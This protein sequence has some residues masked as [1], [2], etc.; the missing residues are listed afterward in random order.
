[1]N[2]VLW[3]RRPAPSWIE[4]MPLGNGTLGAMVFG[5]V[6]N[7]RI[8]LNHE[9]LWRS[10]WRYRGAEER[11][12]R[13]DAVRERFFS[14]GDMAEAGEFAKAALLGSEDA[15]R[16]VDPYQPVGD[17]EIKL[18]KSRSSDYRRELDLRAALA[19]V[20]FRVGGVTH[21]RQTFAHSDM[22]VLVSRLAVSEPK[23]LTCR[24]SLTR[25][26]DP[27]C[28][29]D[30]WTEEGLLG[31][32]GE[33]VE[34]SR[35]ACM[36][37]VFASGGE[38]QYV[39][40]FPLANLKDC[41]DALLLASVAV[42]HDGADP[43]ETCLRQLD[44]EPDWDSLLASHRQA[45]GNL[46]MRVDLDL[47]GEDH[48]GLSTDER[49]AAVRDGAEDRGLLELYFNLGRYLLISSSR[50]GGL[51]TNLQGVWNDK[52][53]PP[54][55]CDFH[56]D[57]NIQMNYWPAEPCNLPECIAPFFDY[58]EGMVPFAREM[59]KTLFNCRGVHMAIQG[60]P[61]GRPTLE[62]YGWALWSGAAPWLA[63]HFWWRDEYSL[64]RNF[65]RER[66]YPLI[67]DVALFYED[68]LVRDPDGRLV[69]VPSQSPENR[70]VGGCS[71]VSLC[72]GATM[73]LELI[74]DVL[75]HAV[76]AAG[77]LG[78]DEEKQEMWRTI[79]ADLPP[80]RIGRHG[81][82]Q[83]WLEDYEE[84]EPGHRHMSHL[85]GLHPGDQITIDKTPE[86]AQAARVSL[87]R[88][89]AAGGGQ[90]GWSRAWVVSF[91]ARLR[92]G[93]KALEHLK[94]LPVMSEY[95]TD[96]LLDLH[97]P[98]IFQID[99]NLGGAAGIAEM[100]LQSH[101][102]LIRVLP[103]LPS[104]WPDGSVKGLRAR[105]GFALDL[106]WRNGRLTRLVVKADAGAACRLHLA[107]REDAV[108][109]CAGKTI[110]A[111]AAGDCV[112]E[113]TPAAGEEVEACWAVEDA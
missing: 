87:E 65:L 102:G 38:V 63:Q 113:L 85:F 73:D 84:V 88:R 72:V 96:M 91:W 36:T 53:N 22:P 70:F 71:P 74:H 48:S 56:N 19:T 31:F 59:A 5:E 58:V 6:W 49:R 33:F 42:E 83:E 80:L 99:G 100:L 57:I 20:R 3:Y 11:W 112:Y 35:F 92:E 93:D 13:L 18:R 106:D 60:D 55:E 50:P 78:V 109:K 44:V 40:G 16:R 25:T 21:T 108:F 46:Y 54:W 14:G 43:R 101:G 28:R 77:I 97:P 41:D 68:Y 26:A 17:I 69:P 79:L 94:A 105:G 107:G 30:A 95:S 23:A 9:W 89:L 90:T 47:H 52:I 75:T 61:W 82:L 104:A 39:P 103:A 51:P 111:T 81:Q 24:L 29:L 10:Q 7:E 27:E 64:D 2:H 62:S 98:S 110:A 4:A 32:M 66:A 1:M 37:K 12:K 67:R 76:A 34:G 8:A 86:L 15:P 45:H